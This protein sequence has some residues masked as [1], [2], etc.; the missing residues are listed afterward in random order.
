MHNRSTIEVAISLPNRLEN[1]N[2]CFLHLPTLQDS[3]YG[4]F[5]PITIVLNLRSTAHLF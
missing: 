1:V 2:A 5:S 4:R 3:T